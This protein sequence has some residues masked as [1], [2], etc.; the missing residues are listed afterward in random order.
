MR[1]RPAASAALSQLIPKV[2]FP[3]PFPNLGCGTTRDHGAG[4]ATKPRKE[5][6]HDGLGDVLD[7]LRADALTDVAEGDLLKILRLATIRKMFV[8]SSSP[9]GHTNQAP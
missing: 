4:V 8:V 2:S 5:S 3:S 6:A 7:V 1:L 9:G